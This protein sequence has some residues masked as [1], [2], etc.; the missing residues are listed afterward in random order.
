MKKNRRQV[1]AL[2]AAIPALAL[3]LFRV[4]QSAEAGSVTRADIATTIE[5]FLERLA[6][7]A[8]ESGEP[9]D[10]KDL[11]ALRRSLIKGAVKSLEARKV[12]V[13]P[14]C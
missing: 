1:I 2:M 11:K 12:A 5:A 8:A 4:A 13:L 14:P 10:E 6:R 9:M 3:I 7:E